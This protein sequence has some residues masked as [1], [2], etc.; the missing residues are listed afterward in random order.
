[1]TPDVT[2][3]MLEGVPARFESSEK[4]FDRMVALGNWGAVQYIAQP[5]TYEE[6][7]RWEA[8]GA[9]KYVETSHALI[10]T[11]DGFI[12]NPHLWRNEWLEYDYIGAPWPA[13]WNVG[14]RVGNSGFS[15]QSKR[16][17]KVARRHAL[18]FEGAGDVWLCRTMEGRFRELKIKYA[19]VE[20]AAAFSWEHYIEEGLAGPDRSF[21]FHGW[22]AGKQPSD[23]YK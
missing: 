6:A 2:L 21:G 9:L 11:W 10:C 7:M 14:H 20:V 12:A 1:M 13:F 16:F 22:V 18:L 19:P 5:M 4:I 23:Y 15:L 17:L 3:I 8:G